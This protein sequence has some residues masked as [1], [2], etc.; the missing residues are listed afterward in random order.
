MHLLI[1]IPIISILI[2]SIVKYVVLKEHISST[3]SYSAKTIFPSQDHSYQFGIK[4]V[5]RGYRCYIE[6][7]PSFRGRNTSNYMP[8][9]LTESFTGKKYVCWTGRIKYIEQARTLCRNW[10]DATQTF[11]DTGVPAPGFRG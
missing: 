5:G 1:F 8:H 10:A 11:I 4:R 2:T 3:Y 7:T 6:Y 9:Y